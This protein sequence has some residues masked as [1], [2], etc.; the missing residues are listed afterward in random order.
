MD[1]II[2]SDPV[3]YKTV[4]T[5]HQGLNA[6]DTV[7]FKLY[8]LVEGIQKVDRTTVLELGE[9]ANSARPGKVILY[10]IL[11]W[12]SSEEDLLKEIRSVYAGEV[13]VGQDLDIF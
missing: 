2:S 5:F 3:T 7:V 1:Y 12:G 6:G 11:F 9:I 8:K 13:H 10:H 4:V